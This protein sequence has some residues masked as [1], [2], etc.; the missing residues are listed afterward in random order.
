M[1]TFLAGKIATEELTTAWNKKI[2]LNSLL[3]QMADLSTT[4]YEKGD[5]PLR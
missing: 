2:L 3:H 4:I 5:E 1:I